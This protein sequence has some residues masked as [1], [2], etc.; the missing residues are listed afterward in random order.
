MK[1]QDKAQK[2]TA[3]KD[4]LNEKYLVTK[5]SKQLNKELVNPN[6]LTTYD[7]IMYSKRRKNEEIAEKQTKKGYLQG[8]D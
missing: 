1:M 7:F 3:P 2:S 8:Y 5:E 4:K 6:Y